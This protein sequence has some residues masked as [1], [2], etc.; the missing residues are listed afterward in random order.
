MSLTAFYVDQIMR[1]SFLQNL[2]ESMRR[3]A[4]P[5]AEAKRRE[6]LECL[7]TAAKPITAI[8]IMEYTGYTK[9]SVMHTLY[10][11]QD[12]GLAKR[13]DKPEF[14]RKPGECFVFWESK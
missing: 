7:R 6:V 2:G 10:K 1:P 13:I 14:C 3:P 4:Q 12:E 8:W 5:V 11:L 9:Q